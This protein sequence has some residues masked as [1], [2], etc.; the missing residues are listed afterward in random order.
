MPTELILRYSLIFCLKQTHLGSV[1]ILQ[2]KK[3]IAYFYCKVYQ[4]ET[5]SAISLS[6]L[7][8]DYQNHVQKQS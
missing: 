2:N 3:N 1:I 4:T 6:L 5:L 7:I 8:L